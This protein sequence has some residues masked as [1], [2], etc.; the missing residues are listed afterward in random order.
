LPIE[1]DV[2]VFKLYMSVNCCYGDNM[3]FDNWLHSNCWSVHGFAMKN[4]EP[5]KNNVKKLFISWGNSGYM[6]WLN[7]N[8]LCEKS[9][10][11]MQK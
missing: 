1:W 9:V 4:L 10:L 8:A 6:Q 5:Y 3:V 2:N 7:D 11:H